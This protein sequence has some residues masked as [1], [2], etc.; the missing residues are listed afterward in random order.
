MGVVGEACSE[1]FEVGLEGVGLSGADSGLSGADEVLAHSFPV[2]AEVSGDHADLPALGVRGAGLVELVTVERLLDGE[3]TRVSVTCANIRFVNVFKYIPH[4]LGLER[5][6]PHAYQQDRKTGAWRTPA[7][8]DQIARDLARQEGWVCGSGWTNW[9]PHFIRNAD[10]VL[11]FQPPS[12]RLRIILAAMRSSI[13]ATI[14]SLVRTTARRGPRRVDDMM[15]PPERR[16]PRGG[17]YSAVGQ[18]ALENFPEKTFVVNRRA[19]IKKL[20]AI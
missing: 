12:R 20:R 13:A 11:I 5:I 3:L 15:L 8:F 16:E 10:I 9:D 6:W 18:Y 14:K 4:S 1:V 17:Y 2:A 19:D 7:E